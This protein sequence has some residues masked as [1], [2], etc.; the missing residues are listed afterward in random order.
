MRGEI[1][2]AG[3]RVKEIYKLEPIGLRAPISYRK[4]T[5]K[6]YSK[7][8]PT[9][10]LTTVI[11]LIATQYEEASIISAVWMGNF[12]SGKN[13][14]WLVTLRSNDGNV[15]EVTVLPDKTI[16]EK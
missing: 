15:T 4:V 11:R 12:Q 3:V 10:T 1:K 14:E 16:K 7:F 8:F 2:G 13:D 6:E 5:I 9:L